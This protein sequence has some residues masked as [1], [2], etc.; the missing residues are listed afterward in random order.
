MRVR[1][2]GAYVDGHEYEREEEVEEP[3]ELTEEF[4][5]EM[6]TLTG[7]AHFDDDGGSVDSYDEVTIIEAVNQAFI[8]QQMS[9]QG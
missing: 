2:E 3:A 1:V 7:D 8:G 5:D 9:W 4:W 6:F